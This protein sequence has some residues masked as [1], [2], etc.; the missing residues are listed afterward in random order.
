MRGGLQQQV[1]RG[2]V[3]LQKLRFR[4]FGLRGR[5]WN[6]GPTESDFFQV[7]GGGS[8]L[9]TSQRTRFPRS[10]LSENQ[11]QTPN[12]K[13]RVGQRLRVL[14]PDTSESP[15]LEG[16]A[17]RTG[18]VNRL[19][20]GEGGRLGDPDASRVEGGGNLAV[21]VGQF[22]Q[23]RRQLSVQRVQHPPLRLLRHQ[24][25]LQLRLRVLQR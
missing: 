22:L 8:K 10:V 17:R 6:G 18:V 5:E 2:Q 25:R 20:G 3:Q 4:V 1:L 23:P 21:D 12:A 7:G 15:G 14:K 19:G 24:R 13:L 9:M 16:L 11:T